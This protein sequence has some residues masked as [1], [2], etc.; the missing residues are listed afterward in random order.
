MTT[1]TALSCPAVPGPFG[2]DDDSA[3]RAW[4][5]AKLAGYP[6]SATELRVAVRDPRQLTA[7]ERAALTDCCRRA[8]MVIY[9]SALGDLAD[10]AAVPDAALGTRSRRC[11]TSH[12]PVVVPPP[13]RESKAIV[14]Q[15][16]AQFGLSQLDDNL[17]AD[18]DAVTSLEVVPEKS[19]RG[20]IPYSS[21]RLLWHTDGYYNSA[22]RRVRAFILHCV[23]PAATGGE[24]ALIDPEM[25]YLQLRD[26]NPEHVR[27]FMAADAMTIP[28][29]EESGERRAAV[30]GPVFAV[31]DATG[32][33]HMRY[34]AR[35]RS[36][37]WKADAA[38][39]AAVSA[40]E[41]L[42]QDSPYVLRYRLAAGEGLLS[43]NVLHNRTAFTDAVDSGATRLLYRAR[44]FD[45]IAGTGMNEARG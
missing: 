12:L 43:N 9:V 10:S 1:A 16:G 22:S 27:A 38:T 13:S 17:L 15:L 7:A 4:R 14:L 18:E 41:Q 33:L 21:R 32:S 23:R 34:T 31:D 28:A 29:N 5:A 36:I 45:R 3:Y 30:S 6:R 37:V 11:S 40:L 25:V 35:T 2:L 44:Y 39:R 19:G 20:Y 42:L 26:T 8:N 24:N